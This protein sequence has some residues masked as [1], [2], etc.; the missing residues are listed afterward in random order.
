MSEPSAPAR[1]IATAVAKF[2][3]GAG[4]F[5]AL[6]WWLGPDWDEVRARF[7]FSWGWFA[8]SI[9]GTALATAFTAARWKLLNERMTATRLGY[10]AYFHYV[11]LTRFV[12]QFT[13][14]LLMDFVGRGAGLKAA[15][16]EQG[17]GRLVTPVLLERLLDFVL[18]A[19]VL[20]WAL[21]VHGTALGEHRLLSLGVLL[22]VA[23]ALIVPSVQP[24]ARF[25]VAAYVRV[26]RWRG[27]VIEDPLVEVSLPTAAWVSLFSI[28]R[29][30][31]VLLQFVGAGAA[32][33]VLLPWDVVLSAFSM[34]Q[35][36]GIIAI[37]PGGLGVQEA[38][39]AGG[40][41]WL[42]EPEEAITLFML[43][44][45]VFVIVNFGLISLVTLPLGR[46]QKP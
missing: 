8:V 32:A 25:A 14:L 22:V 26:K 29:F 12:G 11:A 15:G 33:G 21:V 20:A 43:A 9:S 19:A 31:T 16:S 44:S 23:A 37:T 41:R 6:V 30:A 38:G 24:M 45:R 18:P 40:L 28:G 13:S 1:R 36:T 27:A 35:L 10:G 34:Q 39:W 42:G 4:I 7:D 17:L 3:L 2:L 5:A 46:K